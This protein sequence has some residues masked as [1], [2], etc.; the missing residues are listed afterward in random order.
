MLLSLGTWWSS[1]ETLEQIYW[2]IAIP[3]SII[4][5]IQLIMT[6]IGGIGDT[7]LD[8]TGSSD[9]EIETD[10]GIGFQ[11]ISLKNLIGFFTIFS[12]TGIACLDAGLNNWLCIVISIIAG[13]LMMI[14][15]ASI[16]YYMGKLVENGSMKIESA[17]G[18]TAQ[19]YLRIPAKNAGIGK[20][21]VNINGI[22]TLDAINNSSEEIK[23]GSIVKITGVNPGNILIV[24]LL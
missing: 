1:M 22:K 19:V 20:V 14:I 21:Q 7:D 6:I 13:L 24:E 2:A 18:K 23:T 9:L 15:M 4:F 8:N 16:F 3:F 10:D 11:F 12:W 17:I 5:L